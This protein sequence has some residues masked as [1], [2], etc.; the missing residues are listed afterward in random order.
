MVIKRLTHSMYAVP[1]T[2]ERCSERSYCAPFSGVPPAQFS[3]VLS[4][5]MCYVPST[6]KLWFYTPSATDPVVNRMI[7]SYDPPYCH[8]EMQFQDGHAL[9]IYM[10]TR[11]RWKQRCFDCANYTAV[12]VNMSP[13]QYRRAYAIACALHDHPLVQFSKYEAMLALSNLTPSQTNN[14]AQEFMQY[15]EAGT[16]SITSQHSDQAAS[17]PG[18]LQT[19]CARLIADILVHVGV[20]PSYS[21]SPTP[22]KLAALFSYTGEQEQTV[23]HT[24]AAAHGQ[25]APHTQ[26]S[27]HTQAAARRPVQASDLAVQNALLAKPGQYLMPL[28]VPAHASPMFEL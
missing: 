3:N 21:V 9:T 22:S 2:Q 16:T 26:A 19:F 13:T 25:A 10:G 1:I 11:V 27:V 5:P 7:S 6:V 4:Y 24:Q 15:I 23:A 14:T 8:V 17:Q 28:G 12:D 20:L 18:V